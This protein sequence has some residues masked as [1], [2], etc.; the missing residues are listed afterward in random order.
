MQLEVYDLMF[1][2]ILRLL[3]EQNSS[4]SGRKATSSPN[5]LQYVKGA[6]NLLVVSR[7]PKYKSN[8]LFYKDYQSK[9][10]CSVICKWVSTTQGPKSGFFQA[11][12]ADLGNMKG[13]ACTRIGKSI[14]LAVLLTLFGNPFHLDFILNAY[15]LLLPREV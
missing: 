14:P 3:L 13:G 7:K 9:G 1:F 12:G 11:S 10:L 2:W 6:W 5:Y 4:Y 8:I 15:T